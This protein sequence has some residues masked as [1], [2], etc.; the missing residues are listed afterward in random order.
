MQ[1]THTGSPLAVAVAVAVAADAAPRVAPKTH[2]ILHKKTVGQW[3]DKY[4]QRAG[5][6]KERERER[7]RVGVGSL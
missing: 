1:Q 5:H 7:R 4:K 2:R 3:R 6:G